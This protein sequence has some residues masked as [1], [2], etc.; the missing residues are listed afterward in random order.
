MSL[1]QPDLHR[2]H[3]KPSTVCTNLPRATQGL[4]PGRLEAS[5]QNSKSCM[6]QAAHRPLAVKRAQESASACL[7]LREPTF[8]QSLHNA[9]SQYS[10]SLSLSSSLSLSCPA[11]ASSCIAV[12]SQCR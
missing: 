3:E 9:A 12:I 7:R 6:E 2:Q 10:L 11:R 8:R 1:W 5:H 4:L